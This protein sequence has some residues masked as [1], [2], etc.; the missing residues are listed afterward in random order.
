MALTIAAVAQGMQ[1]WSD[2]R[3]RALY[4]HAGGMQVARVRIRAAPELEQRSA[5]DSIRSGGSAI[6][7]RLAPADG[8]HFPDMMLAIGGAA[9]TRPSARSV[10]NVAV[11]LLSPET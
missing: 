1:A 2:A 9:C 5:R 3:L 8:R 7:A 4:G 10:T 11:I 6:G